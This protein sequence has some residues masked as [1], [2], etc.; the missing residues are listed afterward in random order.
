MSGSEERMRR[1]TRRRKDLK[2]GWDC[3]SVC[4]R[5]AEVEVLCVVAVVVLC[6]VAVVVLCVV[7]VVVLCVVVCVVVVVVGGTL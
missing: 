5:V 3:R 2:L 4:C 1:L 6:V 7:A